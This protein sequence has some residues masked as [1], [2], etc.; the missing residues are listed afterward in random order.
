MDNQG[1]SAINGL[2]IHGYPVNS[3]IAR[4]RG[5]IQG[6]QFDTSTDRNSVTLNKI[7]NFT[8][9][10]G[11]GGTVALGGTLNN[12]GVLNIKDSNGTT[13]IYGDKSGLT[14]LDSALATIMTVG[15][16][17]LS[18]P[19]GSVSIISGPGSTVIDST[20][21]NSL[22]N[23][24]TGQLFNA[25]SG[26]NLAGTTYTDVNGGNIGTIVTTRTA[27]VIYSMMASGYNNSFITSNAANTMQV[28]MF[29]TFSG[30]QIFS[31]SL[32]ALTA[33]NGTTLTTIDQMVSRSHVT[34]VAAGTHILKLQWKAIG[35]GTAFLNSYQ[36]GYVVLGA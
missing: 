15:T 31:V 13:R 30:T 10:A 34:T 20:G 26:V 3:P 11:T 35:G 24:Q 18:I 8:F 6:Y 27:N 36:F 16:N 5:F 29:D 9:S 14:I 25:A 1:T 19:T 22:N 12:F 7:N 17:G 28:A 33:T 21:L 2:D 23:F 4:D 32:G